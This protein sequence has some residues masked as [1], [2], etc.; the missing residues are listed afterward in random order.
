MSRHV[1]DRSQGKTCSQALHWRAIRTWTSRAP[2][3]THL[4]T[5]SLRRM[6]FSICAESTERH[7]E[8]SR[9]QHKSKF[10]V[11]PFAESLPKREQAVPSPVK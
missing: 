7:H 3:P 6:N 10:K 9:A 4:H 11:Q 2:R 1:L 8:Y 5:A